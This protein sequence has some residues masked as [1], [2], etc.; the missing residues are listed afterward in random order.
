MV[1]KVGYFLILL[2]IPGKPEANNYLKTTRK[3]V[4]VPQGATTINF[5]LN[6]PQLSGLPQQISIKIKGQHRELINLSNAGDRL[7]R[8]YLIPS[9]ERTE[10]GTFISPVSKHTDSLRTLCQAQTTT[11]KYSGKRVEAKSFPGNESYGHVAL[12]MDQNPWGSTANQD[13]LTANNIPFDI[14]NSN[15]MGQM[16]LSFVSA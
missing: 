12:F 1:N 6:R 4:A 14:L 16:D 3:S 2:I 8:Y 10:S 15:Q 9:E 13:I 7:L 11:T 5:E